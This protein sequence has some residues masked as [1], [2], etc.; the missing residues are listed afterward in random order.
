MSRELEA[1]PR[2]GR[3]ELQTYW[4]RSQ[5]P[6]QSL[7]FLLPLIVLYELGVTLVR[8]QGVDYDISARRLLFDV[9]D[10]LGIT[11]FG[12]YL[13]GLLI[14]VV[15]LCMHLVKRD[16]WR[17]EWRELLMMAGESF[18]LA[19]PL[20]VF[21][22]LLVRQPPQ[23]ASMTADIGEQSWQAQ[24]VFSVG[25][26]LY[27]E[28]VFRLFA[29]ALLHLLFVDVLALPEH[30][31]AFGCVAISAAA[32]ALYHFPSLGGVEP[33]RFMFY[34][35][36]GVYF[37]GIFVLRGFGIVVGVHALYDVL[38]VLVAIMQR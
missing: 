2:H 31:G 19:L 35:A 22:L 16:K 26:G 4:T 25:A 17:V 9:V 8:V 27:E 10:W 34:M 24:M 5:G 7:I 33:G 15:L 32:F 14:V 18:V 1:V 13:P 36:A 21:M 11:A 29:I 38:V 23:A 6:L 3:N 20:F 37:A 28:L 12:Y 30:V